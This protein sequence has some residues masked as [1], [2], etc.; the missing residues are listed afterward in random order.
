MGTLTNPIAEQFMV[1]VSMDVL[2]AKKWSD[3]LKN[4]GVYKDP[5]RASA[6]ETSDDTYSNYMT[7]KI[8]NGDMMKIN[9]AL[10]EINP[11]ILAIIDGG[12]L[13]VSKEVASVQ[14]RIET[15]LPGKWGFNKDILLESRNADG[16]VIEP[17][18]V[19]ALIDGQDQ[20][21]QKN[22][23]FTVGKTAIGDT[24]LSFKIG[25]KLKADSPSEVVIKVKYSCTPDVSLKKIKHHSSGIPTGFVMVIEEKW[26]HNGKEKGIRFKLEDCQNVKGFHKAI[27]DSDGTTAGYP[28]EITGRVI[29]HEFFGFDA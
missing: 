14:D 6:G 24:Y 13:T 7:K 23:D 3:P 1:P 15:F 28:C 25:G 26:Q 20:T 19:K 9:V 21:L 2:V 16:S 4:I 18:E 27:S 22:T 5:D 17:T 29:G 10:H 11:D 12:S 8:K